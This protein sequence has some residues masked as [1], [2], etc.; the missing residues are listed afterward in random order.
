MNFFDYNRIFGSAKSKK[1]LELFRLW[2]ICTCHRKYAW[3]LYIPSWD[4]DFFPFRFGKLESRIRER[5]ALHMALQHSTN[6]EPQAAKRAYLQFKLKVMR[7]RVK[8]SQSAT[9]TLASLLAAAQARRTRGGLEGAGFH[10]A[11]QPE[12]RTG[13]RLAQRLFA[14]NAV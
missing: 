8:K 2:V 11:A 6:L 3:L 5:S 14:A 13:S 7:S 9:C 1:K 10:P 4:L 12:R